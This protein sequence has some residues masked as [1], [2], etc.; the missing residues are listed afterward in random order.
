MCARD[1]RH[2]AWNALRG[3]WGIAIAACIIASLLGGSSDF[4]SGNVNI[5]IDSFNSSEIQSG[6]LNIPKE[7]LT[8]IALVAGIAVIIGLAIGIVML[9]VGSAIELGYSRFNINIIDSKEAKI[10]QLFSYFKHWSVAI[11]AKL[12]QALYVF[13]WTLLFI[14][15]GIIAGYSYSMTPYILAENPEM[16]AKDAI[17][18]SKELMQGH[19]WEL[20]CLNFSFIGWDILCVLTLGILII[21]INPY[22][23]A[24][25]AA[26]YR[27]LV[28]APSE[29][30]NESEFTQEDF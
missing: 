5:D 10:E 12:L 15:P 16:S 13:L 14:I 21:W 4:I 20:F 27:S 2:Q 22:K 18:R 3:K 1:Y 19:K 30:E 6:I 24:A 26:F 9:C 11:I 25:L 17:A 7:T 8:L 23:H 28:P 29:F